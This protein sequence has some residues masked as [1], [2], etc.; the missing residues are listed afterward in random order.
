M[1]KHLFTLTAIAIGCAFWACDNGTAALPEYK[2]SDQ[3]SNTRQII[4][5]DYTAGRTM[6]ALLGRGINLGNAWESEG[7]DDNGWGNPIRDK[8]FAII[9]AAGFNSVRIPVRWDQDADKTTHTVNANRLQG[10]IEDINLA[11][12]NGLAV[13][14]NFHHYNDLNCAG[15]GGSR[16]NYETQK[17]EKCLYNAA[18]FQEEKT[19]FLGMWNHVASTL[20]AF[21]DNMVVLEI[22]NEPSIPYDTIVDQ[23]MNDAYTVIRAAAPGKTIM[24]ESYHMAKFGDLPSLHLPADGNIIFSGHFYQPYTYTHQGH[25][26]DCRGDAAKAIVAPDS[27]KYYNQQALR[28]YPD[29]NGVDHVPLN[30]G[31]FGVAGGDAGQYTCGKEGPSN[32]GKAEWAMKTAQAA[33]AN[34]ISFHYWG[35][36]K[37]GGF[38]A[39]DVDA[40]AWFPGFPDALIK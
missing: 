23:L 9:K 20:N 14:V 31:E 3:P 16:W 22:L 1:M 40:E 39:Y 27:M 28:L 10:V 11:I 25:G 32:E 35:F 8:D 7:S 15:G 12:A 19:H 24:F 18:K 37:T 17:Q 21:P 4:P 6:N 29:I 33:I 36:G 38:D 5:V 2:G 26:Y 34:G 30:M 13:V